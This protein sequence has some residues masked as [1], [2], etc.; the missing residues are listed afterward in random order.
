MA[1]NRT[2]EE[3]MKITVEAR[4][5]ASADRVWAAW[6]T[7]ADITQWNAASDDW[8]TPHSTND[9]RVGGTFCHRMEARDGSAGFDF[10]G[11]FQVVDLPHRLEF[12]LEDNRTVA[13][14]F[15]QDGPH[16]RVVETF[17]AEDVHSAELQR[18][19]WQSI[20]DRFASYVEGQG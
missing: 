16:I 4:V 7:P 19:G 8:H 15:E 2:H 5:R 10:V 1:V 18:A 11:T 14:T 9:L 3:R 12:M 6:T 17:D 20:L 13:V